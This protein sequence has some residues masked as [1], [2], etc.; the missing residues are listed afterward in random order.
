ME[1][2]FIILLMHVLQN[3]GT[4][5][6]ISSLGAEIKSI[7]HKGKELIYHG[8]EGFWQ[9]SSPVLFPIVGSLN[10]GEYIHYNTTYAM[11]QHGFARDM[12]FVLTEDSENYCTF[13]LN[14]T[15]ETLL[16][17]PFIFELNIKYTL[18]ENGLEMAYFVKNT[19]ANTMFYNVG[20]HPAFVLDLS[21][22][23]SLCFEANEVEVQGLRNGKRVIL[24]HKL[25]LKN[26]EIT[27]DLFAADTIIIDNTKG[28]LGN[29]VKLIC[30]NEPL[31]TLSFNSPYF[32]I[33]KQ[34]NS[35]F[36]CLEPWWG[37]ADSAMHN[38]ILEKKEG[39]LSLQA[40]EQRGH[41][42]SIIF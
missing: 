39:I 22:R 33:W 24:P 34:K 14:S 8:S 37:V 16:S 32:G 36:I 38:G 30:K 10:N 5:V 15:P 25:N 31:V 20:A 17:Y 21:L 4:K 1:Y 29:T 28:I 40:S 13:T 19:G 35:P 27:D 9:R 23:H 26:L 11:S 6:I 3:S 7:I 41:K 12:E 42:W 18:S 2:P